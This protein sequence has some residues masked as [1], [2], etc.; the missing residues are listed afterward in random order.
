MDNR[1][2]IGHV[3]YALDGMYINNEFP[4]NDIQR[5]I[6]EYYLYRSF[7]INT[8]DEAI[9]YYETHSNTNIKEV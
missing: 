5:R 6:F 9:H 3:L 7:D 2:I 4:L 8:N 1:V